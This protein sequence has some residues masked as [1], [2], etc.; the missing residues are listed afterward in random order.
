MDLDECS[1]FAVWFCMGN[2]MKNIN[3]YNAGPY[4]TY[5]ARGGQPGGKL[6]NILEIVESV[7]V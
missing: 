7:A 1:Y 4:I 5:F 3:I 2:S 6:S